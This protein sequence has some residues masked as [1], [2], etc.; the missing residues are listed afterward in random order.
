M[1]YFNSKSEYTEQIRK[2]ET[3][4]PAHADLFNDVTGK[5][6]NNDVFLKAETDT[7]ADLLNA[8]TAGGA[9]TK[10]QIV[11]DLP[12]DA[13]SHPTTFYWVRE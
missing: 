5:L 8:I 4:D 7:T 1:A 11:D 6:L 13:A 2:F 3:T 9:I 10:V 12:T